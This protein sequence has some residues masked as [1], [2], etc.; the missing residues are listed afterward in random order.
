MATELVSPDL[1]ID[2]NPEHYELLNGRMVEKGVRGQ[3]ET[4]TSRAHRLGA[5]SDRTARSWA[6]VWKW[7]GLCSMVRIK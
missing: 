4:F 5:C 3:E 6:A 1:Q 7:N 2:D